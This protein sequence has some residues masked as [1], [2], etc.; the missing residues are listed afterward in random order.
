M[1]RKQTLLLLSN[2]FNGL[3]GELPESIDEPEGYVALGEIQQYLLALRLDRENLKETLLDSADWEDFM[4]AL[5]FLRRFR[6]NEKWDEIHPHIAPQLRKFCSKVPWAIERLSFWDMAMHAFSYHESLRYRAI[7]TRPLSRNE[8]RTV[9]LVVTRTLPTRTQ[10][11]IAAQTIENFLASRV[12]ALEAEVGFPCEQPTWMEGSYE[13]LSPDDR[14]TDSRPR[15]QTQQPSALE[16]ELE[17]I[18]AMLEDF[19]QEWQ[20]FR[21]LVLSEAA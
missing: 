9:R 14:P 4:Q 5:G 1:N 20:L 18:T 10:C 19:R 7:C 17:A 16:T 15:R 12:S 2:T 8:Y 13:F 3:V 6:L 11:E 21:D